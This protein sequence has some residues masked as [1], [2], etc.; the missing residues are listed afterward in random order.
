MQF[1]HSD[2][3]AWKTFKYSIVYLTLLFVAL[4]ADHYWPLARAVL[5]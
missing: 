3:L 5:A 2:E 1:D 4:F